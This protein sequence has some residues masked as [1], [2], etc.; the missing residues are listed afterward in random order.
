MSRK[1]NTN[2]KQAGRQLSQGGNSKDLIMVENVKNKGYQTEA[3]TP[4]SQRNAKSANRQRSKGK[5]KSRKM[6]EVDED[7]EIEDSDVSLV[8][9]K[10]K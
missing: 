10:K 2:P 8:P 5:S 4:L 9:Q 3:Y 6:Q 7:D 1:P